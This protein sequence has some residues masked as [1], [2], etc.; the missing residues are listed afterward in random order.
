[1]ETRDAGSAKG[2][3][4]RR[5]YSRDTMAKTRL[6][7]LTPREA[8]ILERHGS[9]VGAAQQRLRALQDAANAALLSICPDV[10]K[11]RGMVDTDEDGEDIWLVVASEEPK[12]AASEPAVT[13]VDPGERRGPEVGVGAVGGE[14]G[15]EA[16]FDRAVR[17]Q[18]P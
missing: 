5:C 9:A 13:A 10:T 7:R 11:H 6:K 4:G 8:V 15:G 14:V 17:F 1:M 18:E 3:G 16:A 12:P 2:N